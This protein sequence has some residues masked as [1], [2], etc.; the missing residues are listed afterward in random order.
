MQLNESQSVHLSVTLFIY[1]VPHHPLL[2][3]PQR[4]MGDQGLG[5]K[6]KE[7]ILFCTPCTHHSSAKMAAGQLAICKL[8][9]FL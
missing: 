7:N 5:D 9:H 4:V 3:P 1:Y 8:T 6:N 2:L